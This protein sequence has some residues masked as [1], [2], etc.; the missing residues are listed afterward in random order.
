M[1]LGC[2]LWHGIM[3]YIYTCRGRRGDGREKERG[4]V[5]VCVWYE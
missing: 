3:I 4:L 1:L 5:D 2:D